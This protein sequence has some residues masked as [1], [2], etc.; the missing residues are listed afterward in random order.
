[1]IKIKALGGA[2][3]DSRNCFLLSTDSLNILLDC[4][5]RREIAE[6]SRVY[7]LLTRETV[8]TLDM[9]II[10]HPHEDHTAALPYLYELGYRGDVYGSRETIELIPDYLRKWADY[11]EANDGQLPFDRH[12]I[13][14]ISY[15][16]V[17]ELDIP[18]RWGR[19]GHMV[20]SLWYLFELEG[21]RILYTGDS[22]YD[23]LLLQMD[24]YP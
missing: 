10:S 5:V 19:S 18:V 21:H 8:S 24:N 15:R 1:M 14:L 4:G 11:V 13:D 22:T 16:T 9:V 23:S 12:N 7:P 17:D 3:E 20:G 2:G 6:V